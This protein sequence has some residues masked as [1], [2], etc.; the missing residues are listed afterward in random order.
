MSVALHL[1]GAYTPP[2][3]TANLHIG[4]GSG[5]DRQLAIQ[6]RSG[7]ATLAA[8]GFHTHLATLFARSPHA[9][10]IARAAYDPNLLSD[11]VHVT[12][13]AWSDSAP[14]SAQMRFRVEEATLAQG[15]AA[16]AWAPA[17]PVHGGPDIR[18]SE[19]GRASGF[20]VPSWSEATPAPATV[21]TRWT[22]AAH[23]SLGADTRW[24]DGDRASNATRT[25][26]IQLSLLTAPL[27]DPWQ[28]GTNRSTAIVLPFADGAWVPLDWSTTWQDAGYPLHRFRRR[29]PIPPPPWVPLDADLCLIY[30]LPGTRLHLGL[31]CP[32]ATGTIVI[33]I[34]RLYRVINTVTLT[35]VSDG[36]EIPADGLSLS[37][38][39][40]SWAWSWSARVP[41]SALALIRVAGLP[42][43]LLATINGEPIRLLIDSIGRDREF[44]SSWLAVR[45]R[46]RAAVLASPTAPSL[47]RYNT[48]TRTA[49]Q[50]L[51][52]ALTDNGVSI[53]WAVDWGLEDWSVPAGA[54]SHTGSYIEAATRIAEA[55]GGYVQGHDTAQT[56]LVRPY[57]P[58]K[59]WD[60]PEA[61][62]DIV[63]PEDVCRTEGVEWV[64]KAGYNAVWITGSRRDYIRRTGTDG[65][66][67][68]QTIVDALAT[69]AIMTRQR[70]VR[71][72]GDTGKQALITVRL[73]V[74]EE[75]GIIRPGNLIAYTEGAT[76]RR[77]MSRSVSVEC[78]FP[79]V[80]QTI[81]IE[82]REGTA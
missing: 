36:A 4:A 11:T 39:A 53:G 6:A 22:Q 21:E 5:D 15:H 82:A 18:W 14:A 56:L 80:W 12:R 59:P 57:Y 81:K 54:W 71:I 64:E 77:G 27:A 38:D 58:I 8:R 60:W 16:P 41:G 72:L 20:G 48:E 46:G 66:T 69:D 26:W 31:R 3:G 75:T 33:P 61:T 79:E 65:L 13:S 17:A 49:Q 47:N 67:M 1:R 76:A 19:A 30:P 37:L 63:L 25:G 7:G 50:L 40:E 51:N 23:A 28:D 70:G 78:G 73:P 42:V 68:A 55:G 44:G 45:G 9:R 43:E 2:V 34:R 29:P 62:P 24:N 35:R 52:D 32:V 10:V 74:V